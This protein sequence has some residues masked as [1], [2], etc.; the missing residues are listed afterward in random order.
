MFLPKPSEEVLGNVLD[1]MPMVSQLLVWRASFTCTVNEHSAS[2]TQ[3]IA[4][5][6]TD[7][8]KGKEG[9]ISNNNTTSTT[10]NN[11]NDNDNNNINI[12]R[13]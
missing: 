1:A 11:N 4:A 7:M 10:T 3:C 12:E 8:A 5:T 13:R 6:H 9:K 2:L